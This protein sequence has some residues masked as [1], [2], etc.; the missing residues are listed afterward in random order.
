MKTIEILARGLVL[1]RGRLLVCRHRRKGNIYLPGGH[2]EFGESAPATLE[3]ELRE[4]TGL[5]CRARHFVGAVEHTFRHKGRQV[6][7]INL[8]FYLQLPRRFASTSVPSQEDQL[9]F[10]WMPLAGLS[11]SALEPRVLKRLIPRWGCRVG[12]AAGWGG[13]YPRQHGAG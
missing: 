5:A 7:E 11:R 3:R 10:I 2:V 12:R 1:S 13:T 9:E 8:I 6:C 4:E